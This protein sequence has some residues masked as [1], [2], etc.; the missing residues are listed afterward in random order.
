MR[1]TAPDR[2]QV[3]GPDV[4]AVTDNLGTDPTADVSKGHRGELVTSN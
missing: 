4:T 1:A 2:T 3:T